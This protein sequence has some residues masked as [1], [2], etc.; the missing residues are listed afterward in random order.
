MRNIL[1]GI[2]LVATMATACLT[3]KD[4]SGADYGYWKDADTYV[5]ER[6]C[7]VCLVENL[8]TDNDRVIVETRSGYMF[9]FY[10]D[11]GEFE[12]GDKLLCTFH[13]DDSLVDV[14]R[15]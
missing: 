13:E 2:L 6:V 4:I 9:G 1:A 15:Y 8:G 11:A 5:I 14:D 3:G 12:V 7:E 10:A